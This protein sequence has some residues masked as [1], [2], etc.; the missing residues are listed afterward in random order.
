MAQSAQTAISAVQQPV[1]DNLTTPQP[2]DYKFLV[3]PF[4]VTT[5]IFTPTQKVQVFFSPRLIKPTAL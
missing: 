1:H 2:A 5:K 4:L 3:V